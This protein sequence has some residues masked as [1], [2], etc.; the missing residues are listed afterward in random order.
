MKAKVY[1]YQGAEFCKRNFG[2]LT[3]GLMML[4]LLII[5]Q[6]TPQRTL[7]SALLN[8]APQA[9]PGLPKPIIKSI[10]PQRMDKNNGIYAIIELKFS[11]KADAPKLDY[12]IFK[13]NSSASTYLHH[14]VNLTKTTQ[15]SLDLPVHVA[16]G[17]CATSTMGG[18]CGS[19]SGNIAIFSFAN[20]VE[21][22]AAMVTGA[23]HHLN[24]LRQQLSANLPAYEQPPLQSSPLRKPRTGGL[25]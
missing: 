13:D 15:A 8:S 10:H 25:V 17:S 22:A 24:E 14:Y 6:Q 23:L 11:T 1:L 5:A 16:N 7:Y 18:S 12:V 21:N 2:Y 4:G 20:Q 19:R 9:L 3:L